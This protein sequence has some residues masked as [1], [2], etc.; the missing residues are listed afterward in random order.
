[1]GKREFINNMVSMKALFDH[2][3]GAADSDRESVDNSMG[4]N[5][6]EAASNH[7]ESSSG[8][9]SNQEDGQSQQMS[10]LELENKLLKNEVASLNHEV[11]SVIQRA[12]AAQSELDSVRRQLDQNNANMSQSDQLIRELRSRE[13]DLQEALAAKD[14]QLGVLRVRYEEAEKGL[15]SKKKLL[16]ELNSEK[17]RILQD[18]SS[19]SGVQSQALESLKEK[20][21]EAEAALRREQDAYKNAQQEAMQRQSKLEAE[22]QSLAAQL[23]DTQKKLSEEKARANEMSNQMKSAK[24][25]LD[26]SKQE[27]ADYKDKATRILQSKDRLIATLKEG[28]GM[29]D[30]DAVSSVETEELKQERDILKEELQQSK[31]TVDN[32]RAELQ[33]LETQLQNES[34]TAQEQIRSLEEQLRE[35][36]RRREDA[37]Q[38]ILK[39]K[40]ELQYTHEELY[41]QK[42]SLQSRLQDREADIEKLRNQLTTKSLSSTSESE[43]E[44]RL[45]ALTESLIQ[46]QTMIEALSTEKNSLVLQL[47]RME[48]QYKEAQSAAI[49]AMSTHVAVH[50]DDESRQRIPSFMRE[51][52]AD[53]NVARNVKKA[54]NSIDKFSVRLG[55][56]LRRYPIARV[57]VIVYMLI[58]HFWVMVVLLTYQPEMHG[59]GF[60]HNN[61]PEPPGKLPG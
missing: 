1:M 15:E 57:F 35:E 2:L 55:V 30:A 26:A 38:E 40:Q 37:E 21:A 49:R 16:G 31:M 9:H 43:L 53:N 33:D 41:K 51:S 48:G 10:S 7:A 46:K 8:Y 11:A 44:G 47:E 58:L 3:L 42:T 6:D 36:T 28:S 12:K 32:L 59:D 13:S 4:E 34:D 22:Q 54:Y 17:N 50:D 25:N 24:T 29:A 18:Q 52:P 23:R 14:S 20:L 61:L 19:M 45:H 5:H 56:F 27:L 39:Q 60:T